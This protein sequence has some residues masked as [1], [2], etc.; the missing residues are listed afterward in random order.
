MSVPLW[1]AK[2]DEPGLKQHLQKLTTLLGK[3]RF[4]LFLEGPMGAGKSSFVR[5]FLRF[6]GLDPRIPVT[7]P[8]FTLMN[9]Y[10]IDGKW[11]AHL[12]LYRA[13]HLNLEEW[14]LLDAKDYAGVFMEWPERV[15]DLD[16]VPVKATHLLKIDYDEEEGR[17][18]LLA[19]V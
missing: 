15:S 2:C 12:D 13:A 19:N 11:Y 7:S 8:T 17:V 1:Q 16:L 10:H 18:Y 4:V 5:A 14:G 6:S 3:E 9:E